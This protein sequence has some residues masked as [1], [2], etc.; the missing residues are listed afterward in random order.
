MTPESEITKRA[1]V[2]AAL[3]VGEEYPVFPCAADKRPLHKGGFRIATQ[4]LDT[5]ERL[6]SH[7][8][9]ALIGVPT[10]MATGLIA[11][12]ID[13]KTNRD[14]REW[15]KTV[16]LPITRVHATPSG[17]QHFIFR[18][19][20]GSIGNSVNKLAPGVDIRG[21]GGY[22]CW[23]PC[24]GYTI[25]NDDTPADL[26]GWLR[27]RISTERSRIE[28]TMTA[29]SGSTLRLGAS[30]LADSIEAAMKDIAEAS[31]GDRHDRIT[32][33]A[34]KLCGL[35]LDQATVLGI[36]QGT[37]GYA[38]SDRL[39][40]YN[41]I[42][43]AF[44][45]FGANDDVAVPTDL[46]ISA[47]EMVRC[48]QPP[49]YLVNRVLQRR[50]LYSLTGRTGTGKTA[51][52]LTIALAVALGDSVGPYQC[53]RGTVLYLAG[54]N[55]DDVTARLKLIC[56]VKDVAIDE[57]EI[58]FLPNVINIEQTWK[59]IADSLEEYGDV[60]LV[61]VDTAAAYFPGDDENSNTQF[62]RFAR[63]L[64]RLT[65]LPGGPCVVA[66]CHPTKHATSE[67]LVPRGG[68]AFLNEVDGNLSLS[69][70]LGGNVVL[71]PHGKFRGPSFEPMGFKLVED[72]ADTLVDS[73]GGMI[74]SVYA[75]A[76]DEPPLA[77]AKAGSAEHDREMRMI[78]REL[79]RDPEISYRTIAQANGWVKSDG[80]P[81]QNKVWRSVNRMAKRGLIVKVDGQ[82]TVSEAGREFADE[83]E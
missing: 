55:P 62:G 6:F 40:L 16:E 51:V 19:T 63:E 77:A 31:P 21:E 43:S 24:G 68:G 23:P 29:P 69:K 53:R 48:H 2:D 8:K 18:N 5:I 47:A 83:D 58:V 42:S 17:G 20:S 45:K 39:D 46:L 26:P 41:A 60:A 74:P 64:R 76:L 11:V 12:D 3:E 33:A 80:N 75:E 25:A 15:L 10:G 1:L 70:S 57:L 61:I 32:R 54:E 35:G 82:L 52:L 13:V 72:T 4:N 38:V 66:A 73:D 78:L 37:G 27:K 71:Q 44:A 50:F 79:M 67:D 49:D 9:A 81:D 56:A 14:G 36:F 22:V 65:T 7:P 28:S 34:A 59:R 30:A